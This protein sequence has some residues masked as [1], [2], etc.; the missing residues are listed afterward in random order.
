MKRAKKVKVVVGLSGGVDSA[1]SAY[2]LKKAGYEVTGVHLVCWDEGPQCKAREDR[3]DALKVALHLGIPFEVLDFQKEYKER[4]IEHFYED[5]GRGLTPNPDVLCNSEIKFGLFLEW[6]LKNGFDYVATGHYA[7]VTRFVDLVSKNGHVNDSSESLRPVTRHA[8]S[9]LSAGS[10][11]RHASVIFSSQDATSLHL[12]IP[13]DEHKDQTYFLYKLGQKELKHVLFPLGELL[14]SEVREIAREAKLPV[15]E[16]KDSQGICFVGDVDVQEF[17]RRRLEEKLGEVVDVKGRVIGKHKGVWFYTIGQR[18]GWEVE[19]EY[20]KKFG[21]E[22]P[23]MYVVEKDVAKNRLVVGFGAETYKDQFAVRDL[24]FI[25]EKPG[26]DN[27]DIQ[28]RIRHTGTLLDARISE[29]EGGQLL[30]ELVEPQRG[31]SAG[32]SVVFYR[33]GECLPAG[34]QVLGGGVIG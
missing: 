5:Y 32:Q 29:R 26:F 17:L 23:V 16:K 9:S 13:K 19:G 6:A 33:E 18:G 25:G 22:L 28:V 15:A 4:V 11:A 24:N 14:K 27:D 34:R 3:K 12:V 10:R 30:V 2:L 1:V 31:V 20:Q 8:D 7:G 21:G